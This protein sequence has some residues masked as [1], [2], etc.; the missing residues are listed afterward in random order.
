MDL[1]AWIMLGPVALVVISGIA[2]LVLLWKSHPLLPWKINATARFNRRASAVIAP[3]ALH[4][5][6][7]APPQ[8]RSIEI[9]TISGG[10][11]APHRRQQLCDL[12]EHF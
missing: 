6:W 3:K 2:T 8:A 11:A 12:V 10:G 9:I 1:M 4:I 7:T 5:I